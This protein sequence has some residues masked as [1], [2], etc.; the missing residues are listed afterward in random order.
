MASSL[1][2]SSCGLVLNVHYKLLLCLHSVCAG[3][4]SQLI[5]AEDNSIECPLCQVI[6]PS[7]GQ[8]KSHFHTLPT[9]R[10]SLAGAA[11]ASGNDSGQQDLVED[12]QTTCDCCIED[13]VA[14]SVCLDCSQDLCEDH[15][16]SHIK[17][18]KYATHRVVFASRGDESSEVA[19]AP[20]ATA[21]S[22][23]VRSSHCPVHLTQHVTHYCGQCDDVACSL[24][25]MFSAHTE[26][27]EALTS[28]QQ[29]GKES[30]EKMQK[31]CSESI[32]GNC[33]SIVT[34]NL[35]A[36]EAT[37]HGIKDQAAELSKQITDEIARKIELLKKQEAKLLDDVDQLQ[38]QMCLP[39]EEHR[40]ALSEYVTVL[41][42]LLSIAVSCDGDYDAVRVAPW[43][44][45]KAEE[46]ASTATHTTEDIM[47]VSN[48]CELSCINLT[49]QVTGEDISKI[50]SV[51]D[52]GDVDLLRLH[53]E[54]MASTA[55]D[56]S[57]D[58][59]Y[60]Q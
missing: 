39:I 56:T 24:C 34:K 54:E 18:R 58:N 29:A 20:A 40:Y 5:R 17:K 12:E 45:R 30:R 36:L 38:W 41:D 13:T 6:T 60:E 28:I 51:F 50:G 49:D 11:A 19:S 53:A 31:Q 27:S 35:E 22:G 47:N 43:V 2:C 1:E 55:S 10:P 33:R 4:V 37:K 23:S 16:A 48:W 52:A 42:Q 21:G 9:C 15:A 26:H 7:P 8:G 3:C 44:M 25:L 57:E 59:E 32:H 14:T 46:M